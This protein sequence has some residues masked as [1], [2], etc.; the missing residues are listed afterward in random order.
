MEKAIPGP[1]NVHEAEDYKTNLNG[2]YNNFMEI[3]RKDNK[4]ALEIMIRAVKKHIQGTGTDMK[5][6]KL[7]LPSLPSRTHHVPC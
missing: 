1:S 7:M 3:L 5:V 4:D 2:L 6:H